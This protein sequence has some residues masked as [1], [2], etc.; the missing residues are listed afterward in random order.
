MSLRG[1]LIRVGKQRQRARQQALAA[2]ARIGELAREAIAAGM[3]KAEIAR[4]AQ[5]SR[6]AL[7]E[8]LKDEKDR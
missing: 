2:S 7:D 4:L 1:D 5:I 6:P 8:L 3:S